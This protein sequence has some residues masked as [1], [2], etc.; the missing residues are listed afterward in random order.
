LGSN[1]FVSDVCQRQK[2]S[3]FFEKVGRVFQ[4]RN[5]SFRRAFLA[6]FSRR[7]VPKRRFQRATLRHA[8]ETDFFNRIGQKQTVGLRY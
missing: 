8:E 6:E 2:M 3:N 5:L 7:S 1:R 4:G